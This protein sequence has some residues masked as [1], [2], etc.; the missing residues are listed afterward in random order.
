MSAK[1]AWEA[2]AG[3]DVDLSNVSRY[4]NRGDVYRYSMSSADQ[5]FLSKDARVL[6][7]GVAAAAG[8]SEGARAVLHDAHIYMAHDLHSDLR[9]VVAAVPD[10]LGLIVVRV[11]PEDLWSQVYDLGESDVDSGLRLA[12]RAAVALD[13]M[14]SGDPRRW[15]AAENLIESHG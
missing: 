13:L 7:S 5:D 10:P 8:Y 4:R 1:R 3:G 9:A 6:V 15:I 14:E 2:V 12:P 11:I